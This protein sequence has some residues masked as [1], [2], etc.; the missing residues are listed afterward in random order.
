[1]NFKNQTKKPQSIA[2][3]LII[4]TAFFVVMCLLISCAE[5]NTSKDETTAETHIYDNAEIKDAMNGF[6][7]EKLGE[8]SIVSVSSSEVTEDALTDWYFNYVAENDFNWCMI[9]YTDKTDNTGVY[10]IKGY[11]EKDIT[12]EVDEYGDYSVGD[13]AQSIVYVPTDDKT[14]KEMSE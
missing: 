7:S 8:Y 3:L 9:L 1:M 10:A 2:K 11:V 6:H 14:L 4:M 13:S 12:F 5:N